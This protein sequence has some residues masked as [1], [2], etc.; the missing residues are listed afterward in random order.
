MTR[1]MKNGAFDDVRDSYDSHHDSR[2]GDFQ[3]TMSGNAY[4]GHPVIVVDT[5]PHAQVAHEGGAYVVADEH[6]EHHLSEDIVHG[7]G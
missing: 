4:G 1:V 3:E 6:E 2:N 7:L 5:D